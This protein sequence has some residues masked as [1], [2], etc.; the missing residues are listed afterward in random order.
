MWIEK[1]KDGKLLAKER[2]IDPFTGK[3]RKVAISIDRDTKASRKTAQ[4]LLQAKIEA[5]QQTE[6]RQSVTLEK[7]LDLYISYQEQSGIQPNTTR[8]NRAT[9]TSIINLLGRDVLADKLTARYIT[10]KL[11]E[12]DIENSQRNNYMIRFHAMMNWAYKHDYVDDIKFLDKI[13]RFAEPTTREKVTDKFLEATEVHKLL[14]G[15][16]SERWKLLTRFLVLSGLRIGEAIA[17]NDADVTNEIIVNKTMDVG[18][19]ERKSRTKTDCS[20]REVFIQAELM[21]VVK[22]IRR[23]VRLE[24]FKNGYRSDLFLPASDGG[25]IQYPAFAK[26]IKENAEIILKRKIT[27]HTLRHTHV[28][29]L[30]AE[31]IPLDEIAKRVGHE[32]S[33]I[34]K[35]IYYHV[36]KK[37]KERENERLKNIRIL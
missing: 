9:G 2:Y 22:D 21:E 27:P 37:Q 29:L 12:A 30:A 16:K 32:D 1:K 14:D 24:S 17:L 36:T 31:G 25:F 18:T 35:K 13:D 5:L 28:S 33:E 11:I 19:G 23:F 15:I 34:T 3:T 7:L 20:T 26:Y 10:T 4:S 6:S 8:R